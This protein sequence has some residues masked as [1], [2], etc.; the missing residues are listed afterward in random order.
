MDA[1]ERL[2]DNIARTEYKDLPEEAVLA[3]KI[4]ILDTIGCSFAGAKVRDSKRLHGVLSSHYPGKGMGIGF[5]GTINPSAAVLLN[6]FTG[7]I[8]D[9]DENDEDTGDHPSVAIVPVALAISEMEKNVS[10]KDFITAIALGA[11]IVLRIRRSSPLK[12]GKHPWTTG[13]YAP[14]AAASTASKLFKFDK[15]R[16]WDA[17]GIAFSECSNTVQSHYDGAHAHRIHHGMA[18]QA[19]YLSAV[20]AKSGFTGVRNILEGEFGFYKSFHTGKYD[21]DILL[22]GLGR[23]FEGVHLGVKPYPCCRFMHGAIDGVFKL[24]EDVKRTEG[25]T[26]SDFKK[27]TVKVNR[28]AFVLCGR[29][30]WSP[31]KTVVESQFNIPYA[32]AVA[33][34][35]RKVGIEDFTE[36]AVNNKDVLSWGDRIEVL[37]DDGLNKIQRQIAPTIVSIE[38]KDGRVHECTIEFAVGD[39][40]NPLSKEQI[41]E[42]FFANVRYANPNVSPAT[43]IKIA[44]AV[45]RMDTLENAGALLTLLKMIQVEN[46]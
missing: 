46:T 37:M 10:G 11:D 26:V 43:V 15:E 28:S 30:P 27:I 3:A 41:N 21:V 20:F 29:Q 44:D 38:T 31:P 14:F 17:I 42:K 13:T 4:S 8:L 12:L 33:L 45:W 39:P 7:R 18:A 22:E 19:G 35:K 2:A 24:K 5:H 36:E 32:V 9:Y 1:S 23:H 6:T 40:H 25:L 34:A 16:T